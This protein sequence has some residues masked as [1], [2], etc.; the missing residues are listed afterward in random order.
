MAPVLMGGP[1]TWSATRDSDG[2]REYKVV[3]LVRALVSDGPAAIMQTPG[4]P[5]I[6]SRWFFGGDVD[7]W[8]WCRPD[9]NIT[10]H[11][12]KEGD[13]NQWWKVENTFGTKPKNRCQDLKIESP[14]LEPQQLSGTSDKIKGNEEAITDR[15]GTPVMNSAWEPFKGP[16]IEFDRSGPKI[17]I[18]QNVAVLDAALCYNMVNCV[19]DRPLWGQPRRTVKLSSFAWERK[20]YGLCYKYYTRQFEFE[21]DGL[22]FD[23]DLLDEGTKVLNGHWNRGTGEWVLDNINGLPP[24][25]LNPHHFIRFKDRN[26]E[27]TRVILNGAGLPAYVVASYTPAGTLFMSLHDDNFNHPLSDKQWWVALAGQTDPIPKYKDGVNYS[28]GN[29]VLSGANLVGQELVDQIFVAIKASKNVT[30][31]HPDY[32]FRIDHTLI[33]GGNFWDPTE[34]YAQAV[35][36]TVTQTNSAPTSAG[37]IHVEKYPEANFLLL[38]IPITL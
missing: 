17:R 19:N 22:T 3:H 11:Q 9:I 34:T 4:L 36:L 38:G 32:W 30:P 27:N 23:R 8:A 1:R 16:S 12:E 35:V 14:L 26:G 37:Y 6:G 5:R 33:D 13:P 25:P 18:I 7:L 31:P 24:N 20:Y 10:I 2:H 29:L 21:V 28:R 15:F